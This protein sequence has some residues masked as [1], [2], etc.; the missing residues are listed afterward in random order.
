M[1]KRAKAY[2]VVEMIVVLLFLAAFA[3]VAIPRLN[4]SAITKKKADTLARKITIDLRH[5]RT[6]A[7]SNGATNTVGFG[8]YMLGGEPYSSYEIKNLDN[9]DV[10]SSHTITPG[11][12]CTGGATFEFGP[13]GNLDGASD[14]SLTVSAEGKTYTITIIS[15]TGMVKCEE[16]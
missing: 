9:S 10:V 12:S 15:A 7:I 2:S 4:F 3:T 1:E 8:L 13:L 5:T 11:I 16:S 14:T 6:L